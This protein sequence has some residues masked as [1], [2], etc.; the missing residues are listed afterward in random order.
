MARPCAKS[1]RA[2]SIGDTKGTVKLS[3]LGGDGDP[4]VG[5]DRRIR[6]RIQLVPALTTAR[7]GP[8]WGDFV[9]SKLNVTVPPSGPPPAPPPAPTPAPTPPPAPAPKD[10]L[11]PGQRLGPGEQL[12]SATGGY[13]LTMQTDGNLAVYAADRRVLFQSRT[14]GNTGTVLVMQTDGNLVLYAPGNRAIWASNSAGNANSVLLLQG[15]GN[16]VIYA[17]GNRPVWWTAGK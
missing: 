10:R 16:A 14:G 13:V 9:Q 1:Y 2:W 3:L 8:A 15:D 4:K 12:V 7:T 17:P 6:D 11:N 5:N